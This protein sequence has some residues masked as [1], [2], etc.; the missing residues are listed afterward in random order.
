[1][2]FA[3]GAA[4]PTAGS[5]ALQIVRDVVGAKPG[6]TLLIQGAAGEAQYCHGV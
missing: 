6:M 1:M 3:T 4:L 5:T 2:D